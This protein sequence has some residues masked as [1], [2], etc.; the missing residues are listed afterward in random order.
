MPRVLVTSSMKKSKAV[1]SSKLAGAGRGIV[2]SGN[3]ARRRKLSWS[4][5]APK[6]GQKR[7]PNQSSGRPSGHRV[8]VS[9]RVRPD[10]GAQAAIRAHSVPDSVSQFSYPTAIVLGSDQETC[11]RQVGEDLLRRLS[12]G[13]SCT[14]LAYGQTG[15]GKTYTV[16]L[17]S[18]FL[19]I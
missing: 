4:S 13:F 2:S 1:S 12:E 17:P 5:S 11:F 9:V 19:K 16:C 14:L 7:S 6:I 8:N 10:L 18:T 15:S 3:S